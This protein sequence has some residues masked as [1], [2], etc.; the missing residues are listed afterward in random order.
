MIVDDFDDFRFMLK[1]K[2]ELSNYKV[3]EATNGQEAVELAQRE[4]PTLVLMDICLPV[5]DG[6]AAT[7]AIR[8]QPALRDLPIIALTAYGTAEHRIKAAAAGCNDFLTKPLSFERLEESMARLLN[9]RT[10]AST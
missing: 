1:L 10:G 8:E 6:F 2:L 3:L 7:R 5:L 4:R 9:A